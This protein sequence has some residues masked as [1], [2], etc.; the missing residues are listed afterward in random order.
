M[1]AFLLSFKW[2]I[3]GVAIAMRQRN[4][5]IHMAAVIAVSTLGALAGLSRLEWLAIALSCGLVISAEAMNTALELVCD[6]VTRERNP[7]IGQAKDVAAGAV[8]LAA[9]CACVVGGIVF[10][11]HLP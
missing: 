4:F 3:R 9:I 11:G 10:W 5:R 8:L 1:R 6:A 2:A 7:V